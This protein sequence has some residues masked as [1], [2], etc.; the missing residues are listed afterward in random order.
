[1]STTNNSE[2]YDFRTDPNLDE[3]WKMRFDFFDKHGMPG[4]LKS[5][6]EYSQ[7][8]QK[9]GSFGDKMKIMYSFFGLIVAVG[10]IYLFVLGLWRKAL[11][12]LGIAILVRVIF[13]FIPL[14][15]GGGMGISV[16]LG[17]MLAMRINVYY[18]LK[19]VKGIDDWSL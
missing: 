19:R 18:Y 9:S 6:K 4:L 12:W 15:N 1:M 10:I 11:L 3:K 16:G 14:P 2:Q 13:M 17:I 5:G 7:A 8:L